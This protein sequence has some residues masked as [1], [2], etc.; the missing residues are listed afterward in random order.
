MGE[1]MKILSIM[2][3]LVFMVTNVFATETAFTG[4]DYLKLSKRQ[5]V[6]EVSGLINNAKKGGVT[7]KKDPIFYCKGLDNLYAKNPKMRMEPLATVLK[8]IVIME[9]DWSQK[10]VDKEKLARDWLGEA[11]YKAN[12]SR[13]NKK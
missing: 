9:Y 2:I 6:S 12:K 4:N 8:T 1:K 11:S 13:L 5:R 3:G 7:I 10:G